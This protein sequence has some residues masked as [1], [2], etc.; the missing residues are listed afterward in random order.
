MSSL[1]PILV[2]VLLSIAVGY[3]AKKFVLPKSLFSSKKGKS[4]GCGD[5]E[6]GC[7]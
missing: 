1:Q 5:G 7:H 3:L 6:C 4:S 2:Y